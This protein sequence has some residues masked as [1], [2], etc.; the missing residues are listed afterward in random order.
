MPAAQTDTGPPPCPREGHGHGKQGAAAAKKGE[1]NVTGLL[2]RK[3]V[4]FYLVMMTT[5]HFLLPKEEWHY[6]KMQLGRSVK[7]KVTLVNRP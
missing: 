4:G 1:K 5:P 2:E 3:D 6:F 7:V